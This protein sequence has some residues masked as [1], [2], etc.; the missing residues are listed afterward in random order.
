MCYVSA[1]SI[2]Q[3]W[4]DAVKS[5]L[6]PVDQNEQM[7]SAFETAR[8]AASLLDGVVEVA[9]LTPA[10]TDIAAADSAAAVPTPRDRNKAEYIRRVRQSFDNYAKQHLLRSQ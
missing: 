7:P 2:R 5:V 9:A 4:S 8:L 3:I 10:F 6:L 1:A